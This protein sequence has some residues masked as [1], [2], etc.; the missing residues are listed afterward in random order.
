MSLLDFMR[1]LVKGKGY[2][3]LGESP[4]KKRLLRR[5]KRKRLLYLKARRESPTLE[6]R[7]AA[8]IEVEGVR[9]R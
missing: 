1:C 6:Y 7:N 9:G 5:E 4:V 8:W 2:R 3:K